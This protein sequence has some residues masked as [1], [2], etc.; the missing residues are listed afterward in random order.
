MMSEDVYRKRECDLCGKFAFE[1]YL[2]TSKVLDGGFTRVGKFEN[3]GFCYFSVV[4]HDI[5]ADWV[6][7]KLC[8]DCAKKIDLAIHETINRLKRSDNNAE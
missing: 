7:L 6:D 1:K 4:W 8:T 2:G 5:D 3:C